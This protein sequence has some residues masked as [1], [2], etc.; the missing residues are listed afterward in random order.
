MYE[1]DFTHAGKPDWNRLPR[2]FETF[3]DAWEVAKKLA[4][5]HIDENDEF[6]LRFRKVS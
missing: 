1:I 4:D 6:S 5:M 2:R 3:D